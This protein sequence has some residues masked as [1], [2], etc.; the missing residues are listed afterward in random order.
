MFGDVNQSNEF[1]ATMRRLLKSICNGDVA[2]RS[3]GSP[4]S[5]LQNNI[6]MD[7]QVLVVILSLSR[8]TTKAVF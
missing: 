1:G 3:S 7:Y 6:W 2:T 5:P 8:E 4:E